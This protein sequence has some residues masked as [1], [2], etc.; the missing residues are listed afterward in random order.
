M[1]PVSRF[2]IVKKLTFVAV[3]TSAFYQ[4]VPL[5]MWILMNYRRV[6]QLCLEEPD[7]MLDHR[8]ARDFVD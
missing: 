3:H 4:V 7:T 8:K 6:E 1:Q 5:L 2:V